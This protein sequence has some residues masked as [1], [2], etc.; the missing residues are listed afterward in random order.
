MVLG[1]ASTA[2]S[3]LMTKFDSII[4]NLKCKLV[5][6]AYLNIHTD[7]TNMWLIPDIVHSVPLVDF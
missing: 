7:I 5:E 4:Y 2:N 6:D 3:F 1:H